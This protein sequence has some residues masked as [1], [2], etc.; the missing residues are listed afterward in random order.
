MTTEDLRIALEAFYE[1]GG[2]WITTNTLQDDNNE[3]G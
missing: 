3:R 2:Y 1:S